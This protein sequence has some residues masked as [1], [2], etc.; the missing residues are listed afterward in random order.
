MNLLDF[1]QDAYTCY[2]ELMRQKIRIGTQDFRIAAIVLSVN[3]I[4]VTRNQSDFAKIP[5]LICEDWTIEA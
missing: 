2:V 1:N 4:L 5:G 3:G